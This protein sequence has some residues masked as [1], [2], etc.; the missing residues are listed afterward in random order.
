MWDFKLGNVIGL[1][2]KTLPFLIFRFLIYFAI[3]LVAIAVTGGGA[4]IGWVAGSIMG[5]APAGAGYGGLIGAGVVGAGLYFIR[6]YLLY[7][8]KAGHI[9]VL[10]HLLDGKEIPQGRGMI[11]YAQGEVK[12]Y[13][14]ESSVLFG[15]DQLIKGVLKAIN[16]TFNTIANFIPIP[17]LQG[18]IKFLNAIVNMSLTYVDE[19]ILA[20]YMK[21]TNAQSSEGGG[22]VN[23][24]DESRRAL[25]LY[26]QNYKN[27]LKNAFWLTIFIWILT[28]LTFIVILGPVALLIGAFPAL[29]G[30][31]TFAFAALMAWGFKSAVIDPIAMTALMQV[32]FNAIEGQEPDAEWD[33]KLD[34]LSDKFRQLKSKAQSWVGGAAATP[35]VEPDQP[36]VPGSS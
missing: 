30:F 28:V 13:F 20:Y 33:A 17:G 18:A 6:E 8:V 27:I 34:K 31:W 32:Y 29:A 36:A 4:G 2:R 10:V 21:R 3:T 5:D 35:E 1:M 19:V 23:P 12:K 25:V 11:D 9:A 14:K 16:R 7:Q 15:V 24:W 22:E 26:G